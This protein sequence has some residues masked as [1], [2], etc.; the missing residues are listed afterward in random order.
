MGVKNTPLHV[1]STTT[2]LPEIMA[3][4]PLFKDQA[5]P[6]TEPRQ[7]VMFCPYDLVIG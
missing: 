6:M 2:A 5:S 3:D 4:N 7:E 1:L